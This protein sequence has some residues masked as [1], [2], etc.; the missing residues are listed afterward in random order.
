MQQTTIA[1]PPLLL[2]LGDGPQCSQMM[3]NEGTYN[4][5]FHDIH[6]SEPPQVQLPHF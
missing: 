6:S 2:A 3:G 1:Q 4:Y 5:S